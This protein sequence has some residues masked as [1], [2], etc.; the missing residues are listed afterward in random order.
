MRILP[1]RRHDEG[2]PAHGTPSVA[3]VVALLTASSLALALSAGGAP[4]RAQSPVPA[5]GSFVRSATW[6]ESAGVVPGR[7]WIEPVGID[8]LPDGRIVTS[9]ARLGRVEVLGADGAPQLAFGRGGASPLGSA[10]HVAADAGRNRLY[11]ADAHDGAIAV[12]DLAGNRVAAWSGLNPSGVA[13]APDG[14]VFASD[15]NGDRVRVF[16][17]SGTEGAPFGG[18]GDGPAQLDGPAGL[19][20]APDGRI[21]VADRGNARVVIFESDGKAA[22]T[23]KLAGTP[24]VGEPLDVAV[25]VDEVWVATG[26][27]LA[28]LNIDTGRVTGRFET[29]PAVAVAAAPG[30]GVWAAVATSGGGTAGGGAQ[31]GVLAF[32]DRQASGEPTS[33]WASPDLA[34]G[35]FDG[36][37]TLSFGADGKAYLVDVPPRVQRLSGAGIAEAQMAGY[38]VVDADG[39]AAGIVFAADGAA[40]VSFAADGSERWRTRLPSAAG[41]AHDVVAVNWD[42]A[43]GQVVVV[44]GGTAMA[45][46][47]DGAGE[48]VGSEALRGSSGRTAVWTD[49]AVAADGTSFALDGGSGIVTGWDANGTPV[50][51]FDL[52]P[53]ARRAT[54]LDVLPDG[55]LVVLGRDGWAHRL[56]RDGTVVAAWIV[57]RPDLGPSQPSDIAADA[58]GDVYV[59]DRSADVVTAYHWD[60]AAPGMRPP[61]VEKGCQIVGDKT[62]APGRVTI[63]DEVEI[64]LT[65]RGACAG[66][67]LAAD[68]ALVLDQSMSRNAFRSVQ[69]SVDALLDGIDPTTDQVVVQPGSGGRL[70]NNV[71]LLRRS[72]R[73]LEA[74]DAA[75]SLRTAIEDTERELFSPRGRRDARKVVIYLLASEGIPV[76]KDTQP[77]QIEYFRNA[78]ERAGGQ[79]KRRVD[80]AFGIWVGTAADSGR[81]ILGQSGQGER[82]LRQLVTDDSHFLKNRS[83]AQLPL[84]YGQIVQRIKPTTL[85]R[86]LEIVDLLPENMPYVPSSAEPPAVVAGQNVT[87]R[88]QNVPLTGA[89]VRFRVRPSAIGRWPTNTEAYADYVDFSGAPG[90]VVFPVP[91]VDVVALPT[92]TPT[93]EPT[94]TIGH[95]ASPTRTSTPTAT[96]TPT[97]ADLYL[98]VVLNERCDPSQVRLDAVLLIDASTSMDGAKIDAAKAAA[99]S[100]IGL[101]SLP[102]DQVGIVAFNH[103]AALMSPLVGDAA[104]A[105]A[106]LDAIALDSGTRIDLGLQLAVAEL[107]SPRH[108]AGAAPLIILVTDGQ[109]DDQPE[110]ALQAA[111][112][113]RLAGAMIFAIGLGGDVDGTFLTQIAGAS[114]RYLPAPT[115]ADL[116]AIYA[117]VAVTVRRCPAEAFWGRR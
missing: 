90:R 11:V 58:A 18:T 106:A 48:V 27:E 9:D 22:G 47:F 74:G 80:E 34:V 65:V 116:A 44:D 1:A 21:F 29:T 98:P 73:R 8:R 77:W 71:Q 113:A 88:L 75:W 5:P 42:A 57:A 19:D 37:E 108:R 91:A 3:P 28:R 115:P 49:G 99:R 61:T 114:E 52:P 95:T 70:T 81:K 14:R 20:V 102:E 33:R 117:Q 101:L 68:I 54:R 60:P 50:V 63:G 78:I 76:D 30:E 36:L 35:L 89:G 32:R 23:I 45:Y 55:T 15:A 79:L 31:A 100:F 111:A 41:G 53:S 109:Q 17:P 38:D 87:W 83:E 67:Q 10:G 85:L 26:A 59:V 107:G 46:R 56:G 62:A 82:M 25:A 24:I 2:D 105:G 96:S 13:V 39:D 92:E 86:S 43:K 110:R 97:P 7:L 84:L 94:L 16:D 12:F 66:S 69:R 6:T 112:A 104:Q 64:T 103:D 40:V 51:G 72:L 4:A 93:V